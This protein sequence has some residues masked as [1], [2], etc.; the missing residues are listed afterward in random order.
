MDSRPAAS[1]RA[2][3]AAKET[4]SGQDRQVAEG[5]TCVCSPNYCLPGAR[6]IKG[7]YIWGLVR[8]RLARQGKGAGHGLEMNGSAPTSLT[9]LASTAISVIAAVSVAGQAVTTVLAGLTGAPRPDVAPIRQEV[10]RPSANY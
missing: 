10:C 8:L 7:P 5:L 3:T 9:C 1:R 6:A 4:V 2:D